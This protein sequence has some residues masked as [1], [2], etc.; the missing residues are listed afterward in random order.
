MAELLIEFEG[1]LHIPGIEYPEQD[2]LLQLL[3][4]PKFSARSMLVGGGTPTC[5]SPA[6]LERFLHDLTAR[7]DTGRCTQFNYDV[8]PL[9]FLGQEG[10]ER[11]RILRAYG[12]GR[13]TIGIQS[14]DPKVLLAM[15]RHHGAVSYTHMTLPTHSSV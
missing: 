8:D 2:I 15:K 7:V 9:T 10:M 13:L 14:L 1:N 12:V 5:L 11:R 4:L 3:D 6:Q